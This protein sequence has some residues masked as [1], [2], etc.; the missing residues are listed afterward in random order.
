[1]NEKICYI[2]GAGDFSGLFLRPHAGDYLMAADGGYV[3]LQKEG[4]EPDVV[5]GDFD[6]LKQKPK[7]KNI[8][9][10]PAEKD[11]TDMLYALRLGLDK[12]YKIFH[13]YGGMGG[14]FEH[15]LANL[16]SLSFLAEHGAVGFLFG[17]TEV[18][19]VI[20]DGIARFDENA[21]GYF[22]LFSLSEHCTGVSISGLKYELA[23]AMLSHTF[24]IGVSNEF[25]GEK[26]EIRIREGIG[27]MVFA[28]ENLSC[29]LEI[30][31]RP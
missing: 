19:A 26:S 14:R 12:G 15:T 24:P 20:G 30:S 4:L 29:L 21:K 11:D 13:L 3:Y 2:V 9:E 7:H 8:I 27:A 16:Q 17:Q 28:Q 6:S 1:M 25:I 23:D 18:T 31:S 10:L 22:S 5:L